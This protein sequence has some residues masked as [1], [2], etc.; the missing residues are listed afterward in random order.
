ME[1]ITIIRDRYDK[2]AP[3]KGIDQSGLSVFQQSWWVGIARGAA[4]YVEGQV[5]EDGV[6]VGSLPYIERKNGLGIPWGISPHWSH[7][8]GPVVSQLLSDEEKANV[9]RQLIAQLSR[10][11]S[12]HFVCSPH[13]NDADLI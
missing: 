8:G 4:R 6:V 9:L 7:L 2:L 11:T 10:K 5:F 1:A 13:A 3:F 12:F